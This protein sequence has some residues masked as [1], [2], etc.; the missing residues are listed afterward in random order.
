VSAA[1]GLVV[2]L[3]IGV[4]LT[5]SQGG[6]PGPT[7]PAEED[8][9]I[10]IATEDAVVGVLQLFATEVALTDAAATD[11]DAFA[12]PG[13]A[14]RVQAMRQ[15]VEVASGMLTATREAG[16]APGTPGMT[17][18][19]D[20]DH[21]ALLAAAAEVAAVGADLGYLN[22]LHLSLLTG[23][24]TATLG[25]APQRLSALSERYGT[26]PLG[27]WATALAQ[28]LATPGPEAAAVADGARA[29]AGASWVQT[30]D[31]IAPAA[32][33]DLTAFLNGIDPAVLAALEGHPVAG[34]ALQRLR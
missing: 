33:D 4:V 2:V 29:A 6:E 30:A 14:G 5:T 10:D 12:L 1:V 20:P 27:L 32:L 21:D 16:L 23:S 11:G 26:E 25:D 15:Q 31:R 13:P 28:V 3:V 17:Y 34:P 22:D 7:S 8:A 24:G 9:G 18:A 19:Q